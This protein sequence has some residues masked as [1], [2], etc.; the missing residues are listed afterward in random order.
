MVGTWERENSNSRFGA[1]RRYARKQQLAV[2]GQ[3]SRQPEGSNETCLRYVGRAGVVIVVAP[4]AVASCL[5]VAPAPGC[6]VL[7]FCYALH[8]ALPAFGSAL[9]ASRQSCCK[10]LGELES[11]AC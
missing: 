11:K 6:D 3:A 5:R 1:R 7:Y 2:S 8:L 9:T 10:Q 4:I